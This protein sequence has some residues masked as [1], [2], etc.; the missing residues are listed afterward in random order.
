MLTLL[1]IITSSFA[2]IQTSIGFVR[3]K[4]HLSRTM[5]RLLTLLL[6]TIY[7]TTSF[8]FAPP[9]RAFLVSSSLQVRRHSS[10]RSSFQPM[11][12]PPAAPH[13]FRILRSPVLQNHLFIA[14]ELDSSHPFTSLLI[15]QR[16]L[17]FPL[18]NLMVGRCALG[19][20]GL[21]GTTSMCPISCQ[22]FVR[23]SRNARW[24]KITFLKQKC[25]DRMNCLLRPSF[26]Q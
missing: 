5:A 10:A 19:F 24:K 6:A 20:F 1:V 17:K 25:L 15:R 14:L 23:H 8:A 18:A 16:N 2:G 21:V 4:P 22:A 12:S 11:T 3:N 9:S 7:C 26:W 13:I